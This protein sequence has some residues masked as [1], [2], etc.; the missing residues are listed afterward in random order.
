M[1]KAVAIDCGGV[2]FAEGK[3]FAV[4]RLAKEGLDRQTVLKA[5]GSEEASLLRRAFLTE[6][7]CWSR[8]QERLPEGYDA[9]YLRD[10]WYDSYIIDQ[11]I[12]KL[13]KELRG[14]YKLVIFSGNIKKRVEH[15]EKKYS[16]MGLFDDF[17][18]S[19][20]HHLGKY[21][22]EFYRLLIRTAGVDP[23][24]IAC[25]EDNPKHAEQARSFGI[26][27]VEYRRGDI[28]RVRKELQELGVI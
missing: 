18:W 15:L 28:R 5:L 21:D 20:E 9:L 1:I 12:L 8:V 14:R 26:N 17:V 2:L 11:D 27:V 6:D 23:S 19:Y 13:V 25:F 24:E 7:E 3:A 16:F 4:E 22:D 10:V